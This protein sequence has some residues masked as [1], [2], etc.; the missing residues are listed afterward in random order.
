MFDKS[1]KKIDEKDQMESFLK[2]L[3]NIHIL[4]DGI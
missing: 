2:F 4:V 1:N 3:Y